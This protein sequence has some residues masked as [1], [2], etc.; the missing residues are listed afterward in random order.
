MATFNFTF[1]KTPI[2]EK[3]ALSLITAVVKESTP[4]TIDISTIFKIRNLSAAKLF[5]AA[6]ETGNQ[7]LCTLAYKLTKAG[8][9]DQH[10]SDKPHKV[11]E[12]SRS[13]TRLVD[14]ASK[15]RVSH[16]IAPEERTLEKVKEVVF[17]TSPLSRWSS[18]V[19]MLSA[20]LMWTRDLTNNDKDPLTRTLKNLAETFVQTLTNKGYNVTPEITKGMARNE[21]GLWVVLPYTK[22]DEHAFNKSVLYRSI[23]EGM[24]WGKT[25]GLFEV[26]AHQ[27]PT[28]HIKGNNKK[29][30]PVNYSVFLTN[31]GLEFTNSYWQLIASRAI[32]VSV[33]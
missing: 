2:T 7:D 30:A 28:E 29:L 12:A 14:D 25:H 16:R 6:V 1:N 22:E 31:F 4:P 3:E 11:S 19:C 10:K 32:K 33:G 21:E 15:P 8:V 5:E 23:R 24:I 20:S 13:Y 9:I 27:V 26:E 18:G 17:T